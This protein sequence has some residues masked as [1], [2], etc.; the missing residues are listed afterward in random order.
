[1]E[2]ITTLAIIVTGYFTGQALRQPPRVVAK[3]IPGKTDTEAGALIPAGPVADPVATIPGE[4]QGVTYPPIT[5]GGGIL[6]PYNPPPTP[7][8]TPP[9]LPE[10]VGTAVAPPPWIMNEAIRVITPPVHVD[11]WDNQDFPAYIDYLFTL[12][13]IVGNNVL[14]QELVQHIAAADDGQEGGYVYTGLVR[15]RRV[16][17]PLDGGDGSIHGL[18]SDWHENIDWPGFLAWCADPSDGQPVDRWVD[19][20]IAWLA[21][22]DL[23]PADVYLHYLGWS[24]AHVLPPLKGHPW[25]YYRIEIQA[26]WGAAVWNEIWRLG[27][28]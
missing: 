13:E 28:G 19:D 24:W 11:E 6:V 12:T 20:A 2:P 22:F 23:T 7:P 1:M 21:T 17:T 25:D 14:R 3:V 10:P 18:L 9:P 16:F 15:G 5:D 26:R 27:R 8:P 4:G